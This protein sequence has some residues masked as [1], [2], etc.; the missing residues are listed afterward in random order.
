ME[1]SILVAWSLDSF[2]SLDY[3]G[4]SVVAAPVEDSCAVEGK[5][6]GISSSTTN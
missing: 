4:T 5:R 3:S 1:L 2:H 6:P